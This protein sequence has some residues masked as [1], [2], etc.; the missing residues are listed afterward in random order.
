MSDSDVPASPPESPTASALSNVATF[1]TLANAALFAPLA[2]GAF[3]VAIARYEP[4]VPNMVEVVAL[5][6]ATASLLTSLVVGSVR[7]SGRRA[8][9]GHLIS[10]S[11]RA[12][13]AAAGLAVLFC[14]VLETRPN[15]VFAFVAVLWPI[16]TGLLHKRVFE[17]PFA[18][19]AN[20]PLALTVGAVCL[21][22]FSL[23]SC[24][25]GM[26]VSN[27]MGWTSF[28]DANEATEAKAGDESENSASTQ[29]TGEV[30]TASAFAQG[31]KRIDSP[32][33][34]SV[35][36]PSHWEET[37]NGGDG[38]AA[39]FHDGHA[40]NLDAYCA[41]RLKD[42][43]VA[44][45]L[46]DVQR[47]LP[48][49]VTVELVDERSWRTSDGEAMQR[50]WTIPGEAFF[51]ITVRFSGGLRFASIFFATRSSKEPE[52]EGM[53]RIE[54]SLRYVGEELSP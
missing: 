28:P 14:I 43:S 33:G 24:C 32:R 15:M 19:S 35:E 12:G 48:Q 50:L 31:W 21:L 40:F 3:L 37:E 5:G 27:F 51:L 47:L 8:G 41:R 46:E 30:A 6:S 38:V 26:V 4:F 25:S 23:T 1:A 13:V 49:D 39:S 17:R 45:Y 44:E 9:V 36:V 20:A 34:L 42:V 52:F 2:A 22:L 18:Y 29:P 11:S 10:L 16:A 53:R 7:I 54:S